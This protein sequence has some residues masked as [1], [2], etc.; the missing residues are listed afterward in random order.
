MEESM[1][2]KIKKEYVQAV[3]RLGEIQIM[4][5]S[6]DLE[7]I[8]LLERV[9]ELNLMAGKINNEEQLKKLKELEGKDVI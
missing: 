4:M 1:L 6:L 5:D 2:D 9:K 3:G 7:S 8:K